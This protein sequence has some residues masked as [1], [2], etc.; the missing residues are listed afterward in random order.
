[1]DIE[2]AAQ[3]LRQPRA[4]LVGA[5]L[6]ALKSTARDIQRDVAVHRV[7]P[8]VGHG[9]RRAA[10]HAGVAD[11][12]AADDI[13]RCAEC[14]ARDGERGIVG[15]DAHAGDAECV[16]I[17]VQRGLRKGDGAPEGTAVY[18]DFDRRGDRAEQAAAVYAAVAARKDAEVAVVHRDGIGQLGD[19]LRVQRAVL[20]RIARD[21]RRALRRVHAAEEVNRG[22][23][24]AL[25]GEMQAVVAAEDDPLAARRDRQ[26]ERNQVGIRVLGKG[27]VGRKVQASV[28]LR[29]KGQIAA[30]LRHGVCR[31]KRDRRKED[32]RAAL[33]AERGNR[34]AERACRRRG[35]CAV[36]RPGRRDID[37]ALRRRSRADKRSR[38]A[39]QCAKKQNRFHFSHLQRPPL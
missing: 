37:G 5:D 25:R 32:D 8:A 18:R 9:E 2:V 22:R 35:A 39:D 21:I 31:G 10:A 28:P 33:A 3:D 24:L 15:E 34:R 23:H 14:A 11:A 29:R 38:Q 13:D 12:A 19:A 7:I 36:T 26:V 1:M 27:E 4:G 6:K 30:L 20:R 16:F 17:L